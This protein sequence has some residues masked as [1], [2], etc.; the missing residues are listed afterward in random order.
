MLLGILFGSN[1]FFT[2]IVAPALFSHFSARLA[3]EAMQTIFP[4]YFAMGWILGIVIYTL[5]AILSIK[6]KF[7]IK[8]LKWFIVVL[9]L[10][11]I[12][13][14]ALHRTVLPIGQALNN[15]YYALV[16][17]KKTEEA[18]KIKEKFKV[19]HSI[20]SSL[21]ILNLIFEFYLMYS[22]YLFLMDKRKEEDF[23]E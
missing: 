15:Q 5:I 14:M 1:F 12:S 13:Y 18:E 19:V 7:I 10:M 23:I 20:S 11:V 8:K 2:F 9:S 4:L 22:F 3:G 17:E 16:D 6:D 21:N